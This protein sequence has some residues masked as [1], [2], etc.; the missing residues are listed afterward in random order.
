MSKI[1][2]IGAGMSGMVAA[3][4]AAERG[5]RVTLIERQEKP[6]KKIALTGNGKCNL[7]SVTVSPQDYITDDEELL[8]HIIN[9]YRPKESAF[10]NRLGLLR[11]TKRDGVYPVTNQAS[12]VVMVLT[13]ACK[14]RN[15]RIITSA[16]CLEIKKEK[17]FKVLFEE[18]NTGKK[19]EQYFDKCILS[20]GGL[21]GIY[22]ELS[23]NGFRIS[24]SF[25]L[26]H[27]P[28]Y[29]AL[30][31]TKCKGE[32]LELAGIRRDVGL[33]LLINDE[34]IAEEEGELQFTSQGLSGI[35]VFQLT[36]YMGQALRDKQNVI[37]K[38]DFLPGMKQEEFLEFLQM[39]ISLR[40]R[41][42]LEE[43]LKGTLQEKLSSYILKDCKIPTNVPAAK[44]KES[45]L[46]RF[47][48]ALKGFPFTVK[49]LNSFKHAQVSTG[50]ILLKNMDRQ[51]LAKTVP[52]LYVTGEMLNV[53]GKCGGFN[54]FFAAASGYIAG[55]SC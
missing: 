2:I 42:T 38:T 35:V 50:G 9:T 46:I 44:I 1:V 7:S 11:K 6:G 33:Q 49:E 23:H 26:Q 22:Q 15:V 16:E 30:V 48:A 12:S 32:S 14:E 20:C 55:E 41:K 17:Q 45:E 52:G 47:A 27:I 40:G 36:R 28:G 43:L 18:V 29:P 39:Q 34:W 19:Q 21:A 4:K 10:W 5:H 37:L 24:N 31:Q 13:D 3:I 53:C 8:C 54:L 25:D 51:L